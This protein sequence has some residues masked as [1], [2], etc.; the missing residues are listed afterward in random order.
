MSISSKIWL[1]DYSFNWLP[2]R[3]LVFPYLSKLAQ[4]SYISILKCIGLRIEE[5][6]WR[7][8]ESVLSSHYKSY[9]DVGQKALCSLTYISLALS[10][11]VNLNRT[12]P[13]IQQKPPFTALQPH[14][15]WQ[16]AKLKGQKAVKSAKQHLLIHFR[17]GLSFAVIF[18]LHLHFINTGSS[19]TSFYFY[20]SMKFPGRQQFCGFMS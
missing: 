20:F 9:D 7:Q 5:K 4:S 2:I 3:Q 6:N 15:T 11:E 13:F 18:F 10:K 16:A 1:I 12:Q 19:A 8:H 17:F 14:P